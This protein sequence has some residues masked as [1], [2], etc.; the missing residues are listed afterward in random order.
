[1]KKLYTLVSFA[2]ISAALFAQSTGFMSPTATALPNGFTN[3]TNA[4]T[5]DNQ[6]A[7]V[8]HQSGCRCPF[9]Y[10]SWN[11][12][13]NYSSSQLLGPFG[14]VD[15]FGTAGS[16]TFT[17]GHAWTLS[18]LTNANLRLKIA[19]P[20]TLIEQGYSTFN[21]LIPNGATI[22]GIEVRL[23]WHGDSTYT[24]EY[25][26][27]AQVNVYYTSTTT[28]VT[29]TVS[30]NIQLC[31]NPANN[32]I[33]ISSSDVSVSG[34]SISSIDGKTILKNQSTNQQP[35]TPYEISLAEL[36]PG[37]YFISMETEQGTVVRKIM[38]Q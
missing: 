4:F 36:S 8:A 17:W 6:W 29:E 10:L 23:E 21:F 12:G 18:E 30:E 14:T 5:S 15:A 31:P 24:T 32:F 35:N 19:N 13:A 3:P 7:T 37:V 26:D 38:V 2:L 11:G 33:T 16:P 25:L 28:G 34:Y 20:S 1:M 27:H 22:T 9:L